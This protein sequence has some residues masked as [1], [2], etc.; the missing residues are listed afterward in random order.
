MFWYPVGIIIISQSDNKNQCKMK[1]RRIKRSEN[2]DAQKLNHLPRSCI[3]SQPPPPPPPPPFPFPNKSRKWH[4]QNRT[5]SDHK[6][7]DSLSVLGYCFLQF[8]LILF[9]VDPTGV[10]KMNPVL[11][12][13]RHMGDRHDLSD[14]YR[15]ELSEMRGHTHKHTYTYAHT[16]THTHTCMRAH[17]HTHI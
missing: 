2:Q 11:L 9:Q 1:K 17:T 5:S 4:I 8:F 12:G 14:M 13:P 10:H 16:H 3:Y 7:C 6:R 15:N